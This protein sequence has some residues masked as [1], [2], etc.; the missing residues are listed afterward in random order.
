MGIINHF[1][2]VIIGLKLPRRQ[3]II[4]SLYKHA[5]SPASVECNSNP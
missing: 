3:Y 4:F 5:N 1:E 2:T